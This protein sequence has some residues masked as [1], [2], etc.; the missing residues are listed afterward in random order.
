MLQVLRLFL[1][2]LRSDLYVGGGPGV[3]IKKPLN[4]FLG[5][6]FLASW[7]DPDSAATTKLVVEQVSHHPPITAVHI[8]AP[9]HGVRADSYARVEMTFKGMVHIRR[10]GHAMIHLDELNEDYL[11][12]FPDVQIRGFLGGCLYPEMVGTYKII[13]SS[14]YE[15]EIKFSGLGFLG[16]GK[17]NYF[18]ARVYNAR[19]P[20]TNFYE[21]SGVWS[22]GWQVKDVGTGEI[23]ETYDVDA[24]ANQPAPMDI[25]SVDEQDPWESQRAWKDVVSALKHGELRHASEAKHRLEEGQR[26]MRAEERKHH[27]TWQPL[28]FH[29]IP[30]E[31]HDIFHRLT[32]GSKWTLSDAMTK[33]V[34]KFNGEMEMEKTQRPYRGEKTPL[35]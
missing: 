27:E 8:A 20:K 9:E 32:R 14:G 28:L 33:G 5:E 13:S 10:I 34:W 22:E 26:H 23:I 25:A 35:G 7:T 6:L 19:D 2:A 21:A 3:S 30:G 18:E 4:A 16:G 1:A 24:A 31:E 17:K 29:S 12:P 15:S 11:L